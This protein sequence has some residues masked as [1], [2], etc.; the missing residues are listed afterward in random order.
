MTY[1]CENLQW[2]GQGVWYGPEAAT[3]NEA[4]A[5]AMR[6]VVAF[7]DNNRELL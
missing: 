2:E 3:N 1:T 5:M 7:C 6:D 4:E